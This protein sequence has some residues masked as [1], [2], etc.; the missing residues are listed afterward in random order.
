ME[1]TKACKKCLV[2]KPITKYGITAKS[3]KASKICE[4]CVRKR[5]LD[6]AKKYRELNKEK[7]RE[8]QVQFRKTNPDYVKQYRAANRDRII[9]VRKEHY[10]K[11]KERILA[12]NKKT[13]KVRAKKWADKNRNGIGD[14]YVKQLLKVKGLPYTEDTLEIQRTIVK[15]TRLCKSRTSNT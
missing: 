12:I 5:V 3:K 4:L 8:R 14:T 15:I 9:K 13:S 6:Y 1:E 11:N 10:S 2:E 7:V